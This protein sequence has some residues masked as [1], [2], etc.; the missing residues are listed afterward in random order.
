M[1]SGVILSILR[2]S[3]KR[4]T[5]AVLWEI[6]MRVKEEFKSLDFGFCQAVSLRVRAA[7]AVGTFNQDSSLKQKGCESLNMSL[8]L[9][10]SHSYSFLCSFW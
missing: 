3:T 1:P 9:I 2:I 6:G 8:S 5:N 4:K 7:A 10:I